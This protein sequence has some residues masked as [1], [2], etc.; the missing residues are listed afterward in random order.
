MNESQIFISYANEN[1]SDI[2][3]VIDALKSINI[4]RDGDKVVDTSHVIHPGSNIREML[5]EA[6]RASSKVIVFW[7]DEALNSEFVNY[8]V[9]MAE[10][11]GKP[12]IL[13]VPAGQ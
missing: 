3:K 10:A 12:I 1:K 11:L 7:N 6:V 4:V 2:L 9:A 13:V 5:R 8:E